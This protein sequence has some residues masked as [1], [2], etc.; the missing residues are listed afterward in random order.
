[1]FLD[2]ELC[3]WPEYRFVDYIFHTASPA[4]SHLYN[5]NPLS[6]IAPN[7]LGTQ[8]LLNIGNTDNFKGMVFFSSGEVMGKTDV[9]FADEKTYGHLDPTDIRSCY[10]ESKR[11]GENLCK[12]YSHQYGIHTVSVRLDHTY[13]ITMDLEN[14]NR[15]FAE[16]V[17]N[18]VKNED[19]II[20]SDG[21]SIR[22][23]VYLSDAVRGIFTALLKGNSGETYN[24]SNNDCRVTIKELAENLIS[25]YPEKNLQI[26]YENRNA[27]GIY[28]ENTNK[29]CS[30]LD[31]GKIE[32]LGYKCDYGIVEGFRRVVEYLKNKGECI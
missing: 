20:K 22:T 13:G 19:I 7:I 30:S 12:C 16:F 10:G 17:S 4:S 15:V 14:D 11:M 8:L 26:V 21:L 23:F 27:D 25:L 3:E 31:T 28:L 24:V 2:M 18:I 5:T 1:M 9:E 32:K 6:V 29:F